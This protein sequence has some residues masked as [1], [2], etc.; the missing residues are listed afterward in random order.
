M[1]AQLS[2]TVFSEELYSIG[3]KTFVVTSDPWDQI[4]E[5]DKT[6]LQKILQAVGLSIDAVVVVGEH[7]L[8]PDTIRTR[9]GRLIYFGGNAT[10]QALFEVT[11]IHGVPGLYS[12]PLK[13]LQADGAGKQR[14]WAGLK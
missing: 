13:Q 9:A 3:K 7:D 11:A 1:I 12:P 6:L 14:L 2:E 5:V 4:A 10:Q 8:V